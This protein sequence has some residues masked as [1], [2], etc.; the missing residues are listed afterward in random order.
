[1]KKVFYYLLSTVYCL[2]S[3]VASSQTW[4][5]LSGF[6]PYMPGMG[7]VQCIKQINGKLYIGGAFGGHCP[8]QPP[9]YSSGESPGG[10][11]IA[12][13]DGTTWDSLGHG[14][15]GLVHAIEYYNGEIYAGYDGES[16]HSYACTGQ[17]WPNDFVHNTTSIAKWNGTQWKA[18]DSVLS[19]YGYYDVLA[20]QYKNDLYIGGNFIDIPTINGNAKSIIKYNGS[21]TDN[22][23]GGLDWGIGGNEVRSMVVWN[24]ELYV[25]GAFNTAGGVPCHNIAKWNGTKWDSV[26][27]G[28]DANGMIMSLAL[29]S[30]NNV[31]YAAGY[32]ESVGGVPAHSV[33]KWDG[34]NWSALGI[35]PQWYYGFSAIGLF[36]GEI[37][38]GGGALN[39]SPYDSTLIK[40]DGSKWTVMPGI[41]GGT[42]CA[43]Q[44]YKGNFYIGGI[45]SK[46]DTTTVNGIACYGD[47]CPGKLITMTLP[48]AVNEVSSN[49]LKFKVF[50]NPAKREIN[51]QVIS[52]KPTANSEKYIARIK[53]ALGQNIFEQKFEKELKINTSAFKQG[54][55]FVEVCTAEG[56]VC[57]TEKVV[58]E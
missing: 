46:I 37:Y 42:I 48:Y 6:S 45:I 8:D 36:K 7:W 55:Y 15:Y 47:S 13:F 35:P 27:G 32:F 57:H 16:G 21:T 51:I 50:P 52:D 54:I 18:V 31:L 30:V 23:L 26:G 33:A 10:N 9:P 29:D 22:M 43:M 24:G 25:A 3:T 4:H 5:Q 11:C 40:W 17:Y 1:M 28:V 38:V 49:S 12:T 20:L 53:N 41:V 58:L 56:V 14:V 19:S 39:N 34:S 2:L 44:V